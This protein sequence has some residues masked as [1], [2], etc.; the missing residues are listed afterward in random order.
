MK[1]PNWHIYRY[2]FIYKGMEL[3]TEKLLTLKR[4]RLEQESEKKKE[5]KKGRNK[6]KNKQTLN[7]STGW[8]LHCLD[9]LLCPFPDLWAMDLLIWSS[10]RVGTR[11]EDVRIQEDSSSILGAK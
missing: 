1:R 11:G 6:T 2:F 5:K 7:M 10:Y 4:G 8:D 3:G 9:S